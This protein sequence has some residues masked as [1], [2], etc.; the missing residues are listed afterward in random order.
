MITSR[1]CIPSPARQHDPALFEQPAAKLL[2]RGPTDLSTIGLR[3]QPM[4]LQSSTVRRT[5][6]HSVSQL[7][8]VTR[9]R[10][11][12]RQVGNPSVSTTPRRPQPSISRAA[13]PSFAVLPRTAPATARGPI[14]PRANTRTHELLAPPR[15]AHPQRAELLAWPVSSCAVRTRT[16]PRAAYLLWSIRLHAFLLLCYLDER[17]ARSFY[18]TIDEGISSSLAI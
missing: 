16:F 14:R 1:A 3:T 11:E 7:R 2:A 15:P 5:Q 9:A 6:L 12:Q 8:R 18:R 13:R 17:C 4:R 10:A